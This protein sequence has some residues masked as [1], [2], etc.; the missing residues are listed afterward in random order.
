[1]NNNREK[2][3][4]FDFCDTLVAFQTADAFVSF[5]FEKTHSKRMMVLRGIH[6]L[7][8]KFRIVHILY[9]LFPNSSVN[10]RII[11]YQLVGMDEDS[12]NKLAKDYYTERIRPALIQ[13]TV[14][15]LKRLQSAGY[16]IVLNSGGYEPYLNFFAADYNIKPEDLLCTRFIFKHGR[17]SGR[18]KGKDCMGEQ[19]VVLMNERFDK[20]KVYSIVYSDSLSD[21]P[22]FKWANKSFIVEKYVD[23]NL[24]RAKIYEKK[25]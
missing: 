3:A 20:E 17:C 11:A 7:L 19:K 24:N 25:Y 6:S 16:R 14:L 4:I 1:M 18:F 13:D 10:K 22:L 21:L 2:L 5:V 8:Y 12:I 9:R 23:N 15:E